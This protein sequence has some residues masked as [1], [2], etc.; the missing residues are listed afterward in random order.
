MNGH[1]CAHCGREGVPQLSTPT[2][3]FVLNRMPNAFEREALMRFE[4]WNWRQRIGWR[5]PD[6]P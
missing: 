4:T 2:N 6:L 1:R 3:R 5:A